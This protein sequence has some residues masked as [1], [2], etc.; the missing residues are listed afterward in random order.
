MA[1]AQQERTLGIVRTSPTTGFYID[2][3]RSKSSLPTQFHDYIYRNLGETL[4]FETNDKPL[5]W[6]KDEQRFAASANKEWTKN[7]KFRHPGW[8]FF[9]KAETVSNYPLSIS[10]LFS[11]EKLEKTPVKMKLF[12]G[13]C[14]AGNFYQ[15]HYEFG[16]YDDE[17]SKF[18]TWI[19][20]IV[21]NH[22]L[23]LKK[24]KYEYLVEGF[25]DFFSA[26]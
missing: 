9:K 1:E 5:S 23:D 15:N 20:R 26:I 10:A 2:I 18:T 8:H 13:G 4:T 17:K 14:S 3:F 7:R 6:I 11:A 24:Q 22:I 25:D 21:V 16:K 19:Y 12:I